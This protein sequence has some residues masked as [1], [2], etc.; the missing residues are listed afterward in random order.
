MLPYY[1]LTQEAFFNADKDKNQKKK[2]PIVYSNLHPSATITG[3]QHSV[4]IGS[5]KGTIIKWNS[6]VSSIN[7]KHEFGKKLYN[8]LFA[9]N[10]LIDVDIPLP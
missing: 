3:F 9:K 5:Q 10:K 4:L 1:H 7:F 8:P 2:T 6:N